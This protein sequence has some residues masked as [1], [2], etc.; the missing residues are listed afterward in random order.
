MS[1]KTKLQAF[2]IEEPQAT[3]LQL[4]YNSRDLSLLILLP[5]DIEGLDQVQSV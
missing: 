2:H 3:G 5:E 4:Y 1:M